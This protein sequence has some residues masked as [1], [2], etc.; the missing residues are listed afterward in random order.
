MQPEQETSDR[1]TATLYMVSTKAFIG[2]SSG[3]HSH[4]EGAENDDHDNDNDFDND[5]DNDNDLN[6]NSN[7]DPDVDPNVDLNV[8]PDVDPDVDEEAPNFLRPHSPMRVSTP[9]PPGEQVETEEEV[10]APKRT[11][12]QVN[13]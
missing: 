8:D 7:V 10:E 1:G 6:V 11:G 13:V 12:N 4:V 5:N 3:N 2:V 9:P